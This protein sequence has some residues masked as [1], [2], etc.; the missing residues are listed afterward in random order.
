MPME[1]H[2]SGKQGFFDCVCLRSAQA[3]FAPNDI[4]GRCYGFGGTAAGPGITSGALRF[5][6]N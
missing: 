6:G 3:S 1:S 2:C 4:R 5:T